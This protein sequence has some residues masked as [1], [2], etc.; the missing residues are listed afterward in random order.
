MDILYRYYQNIIIVDRKLD[1]LIDI[2]ISDFR[3]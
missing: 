2:I 1:I 3:Q